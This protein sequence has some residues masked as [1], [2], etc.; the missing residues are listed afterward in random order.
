MAAAPWRGR[1]VAITG[2]SKGIGAALA[3]RVVGLGARV[4]LVARHDDDLAGV[5]AGLPPGSAVAV[6][7]DVTDET[8]LGRALARIADELG[9]IDI[10]VNN[11][12]VG[13]YRALLDTSPGDL[14]R[15]WQVN[16]A[17][18]HHAVRAVVPA[19]VE[20]GRGVVVNVASIAGRIGAPMEG[21]YSATKF[22][23]IG[24]S[25]SLQAE[26]DGTGVRV[27]VV[28]PGPV[29]TGFFDARGVPYGRARPRPIPA[30]KVADAIV[31]AVER[32]RDETFVP[33]WLRGPVVLKAAF[34]SLFRTTSRLDRRL[35]ERSH[36]DAP[37]TTEAWRKT[38]FWMGRGDYIPQP[39]LDGDAR[40]DVVIMGGGYTGLWTAIHLKEMD[41]GLDVMVLE[42]EVAGF[43]ASGRNGG[44][45]MTMVGRNLHDLVRKVGPERARATHLAMRATLGQ[46]EEF[47]AK[48]SIDAAITHPGLLTVSNGPDQDIR[49]RH[50]LEAAARLGL[51]DYRELSGPEVRAMVHSERLRCGH[52][53]EDAL[54]VDPAALNRGLR[55]AALRR[56]VRLHEHTPVTRLSEDGPAGV[57][58]ET[59]FGTVRADRAVVATNAY[60]HAVPELRRYIFTVYAHIVVTRPLTDEQWARV[61]WTPRLGIEDK[62]IM[63]HFH[64]PTPDGRILWGGRDAP[65]ARRGPDARRERTPRIFSRLEET[66]RWTFPQLSD[67]AV[68]SG[69]S[70]P[71]C[72]TVNCFATVGWLGRSTRI[73]Y[74]VGYAGHGVGPSHL[75]A[76]ILRDMLL[77]RRS[78]LL[79]LPMVTK[80]P[81]P[82]PPAALRWPVL[83]AS[84]R[85]LQRADDLGRGADPATR[86]VLK[87]LQ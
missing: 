4:G 37:A 78:D 42:G 2:G 9:P 38:S 24:M 86:A 44:F 20:R 52:L 39:Q 25:E 50:D 69:W 75:S 65:V 34:P 7:A 32:G 31:A 5:V 45:A 62:R 72:G 80:R 49:I 46:I 33:G 58:A 55:D 41:P 53:E 8:G 28:D 54:L 74:S 23:V 15:L 61:G 68:E 21:A 84:Q 6:G 35:Q 76:E 13:H 63:P 67:V 10:L 81:V 71:V 56:G 60:A 19:M 64:R 36:L 1:V 29:A 11:A 82:L 70:G 18:V 47:C 14:E 85:F 79:D 57:V 66:F 17:G 16:V 43:G 87:A 27:C 22:A 40:C 12:G 30:H 83:H 26:L 73:A 51:D 48:E 3:H 77:E 59:P